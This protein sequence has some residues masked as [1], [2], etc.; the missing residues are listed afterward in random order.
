M[1]LSGHSQDPAGTSWLRISSCQGQE[2]EESLVNAA[3]ATSAPFGRGPP[4]DR[5]TGSYVRR[6][7]MRNL[8]FR[9]DLDLQLVCFPAT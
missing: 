6:S 5:E 9:Q 1:G 8:P 3:T 2:L 7:R 4:S